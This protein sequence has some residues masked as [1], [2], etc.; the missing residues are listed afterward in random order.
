MNAITFKAG[1]M[2]REGN[3]LKADDRK[4]LVTIAEQEGDGLLHFQWSS[5]RTGRNV[6]EDVGQLGPTIGISLIRGQFVSS[7]SFSRETRNWS[8]SRKPEKTPEFSCLDLKE[9][10]P[11]CF[12]GCKVG[13]PLYHHSR[14]LNHFGIQSPKTTTRRSLK[15]SM[16]HWELQ[17]KA[18]MT[19]NSEIRWLQ[20]PFFQ[21][22]LFFHLHRFVQGDAW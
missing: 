14:T 4:G 19:W 8:R 9:T 11:D 5:D 17:D 3:T 21:F 15:E 12:S 2:I 1:K 22:F 16:K 7:S 13:A 20:A 18:R 10:H 6:E